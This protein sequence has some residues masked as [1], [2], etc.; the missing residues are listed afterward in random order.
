MPRP[1]E[2]RN[3]TSVGRG[4]DSNKRAQKRPSRIKKKKIKPFDNDEYKRMEH[5]RV[6]T[7]TKAENKLKNPVKHKRIGGRR[8]ALQM[9]LQQVATEKKVKRCIRDLAERIDQAESA[10]RRKPNSA[11]RRK[12]WT[13]WGARTKTE[14]HNDL[15]VISGVMKWAAKEV[16]RNEKPIDDQKLVQQQSRKGMFNPKGIAKPKRLKRGTQRRVTFAKTLV[17]SI[18]MRP[19]STDEKKLFN[20]E[21]DEKR[22]GRDVVICPDLMEFT[23]EYRQQRQKLREAMKKNHSADNTLQLTKAE[24]QRVNKNKWIKVT[25]SRKTSKC[26]TVEASPVQC[27]NGYE[28]LAEAT[29]K[30][31]PLQQSDNEERAPAPINEE[32]LQVSA[33]TGTKNKAASRKARRL[34]KKMK[35]LQLN[36]DEEAFFTECITQAEDERTEAAQQDEQNIW[37]QAEEQHVQQPK[38][39]PSLQSTS[40]EVSYRAQN[41]FRGIVNDAMGNKKR[42]KFNLK[43][44]TQQYFHAKDKLQPGKWRDGSAKSI[45]KHHKVDGEAR[46]AATAIRVDN[47]TSSKEPA[48]HETR[49]VKRKRLKK[50]KARQKKETVS[51][52]NEHLTTEKKA[53]QRNKSKQAPKQAAMLGEKHKANAAA[54]RRKP[55]GWKRRLLSFLYDSGADGHYPTEKMRKEAG[56]S[57]RGK[58]TKRVAVADGSINKGKHKVKLPFEGLSTQ[59][60]AG[61]TFEQF[62]DSLMSVGQ[63]NDDGNISIFTSNGVTVHKEEDVLITC[64][65]EPILVGV[66]DEKGRYRIPLVQERNSWKPRTP[67]KTTRMALQK[68][69][70]VY[71]LPSTEECIKW[72]H[73]ACGFPVKSTWIKAIEAGNFQGWPL[74]T[75]KRVKKY[76]PETTETPKGHLNQV[77]QNIRSTKAKP[78]EEPD[79]TK[80][81]GKKKKDVYLKVYDMKEKVYSDQTGRFPKTSM[82]GNKYIMVM[83]EV[84][85]NVILV[86]PMK[87]RHDD[88]MKR[89]YTPDVETQPCWHQAKEARD[90]Q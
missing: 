61:D 79:T 57:I 63:V 18:H 72:M 36:A 67:N 1:A 71:D 19:T 62:E 22:A 74:L 64:K 76:Y 52:P 7:S 31:P 42:V 21:A 87:S 68:A 47:A 35:R 90:G 49:K 38:V 41:F 15:Q 46:P 2:A 39:K 58:S 66:R 86:E 80:L 59:A 28:A 34:Q 77:R 69:N 5:W 11:H 8:K 89:A 32:R 82:Q 13:I 12:A 25:K 65:G 53:G 30:L 26:V 85:S 17:T 6:S 27:S 84:D 50:K 29:I 10:K 37:R 3:S 88:E 20:T 9:Y 40:R 75:T 4:R 51:R 23:R 78:F 48:E 54:H 24:Q 16:A 44:N 60:N 55:P 56:L 83:V 70:S 33:T 14:Q 43:R 45:P 73:A 81:R